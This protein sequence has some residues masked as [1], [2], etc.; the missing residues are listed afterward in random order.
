MSEKRYS[1]CVTYPNKNMLGQYLFFRI[2]DYDIDTRSLTPAT[3][4]SVSEEDLT[5]PRIIG[6]LPKD[7]AANMAVIREWGFKE[8]GSNRTISTRYPANV[9]EVIFPQELNTI[10][11]TDQSRIREVL[12]D[13]IMIDKNAGDELLIIIGSISSQY[14]ALHCSKKNMIHT[15]SIYKIHSSMS[16]M[17]HS[18]HYLDEYYIDKPDVLDTDNSLITDADGGKVPTRYFYRYT[19]LPKKICNFPLLDLQRYVPHYISKCLKQKKAMLQ[20]SDHDIQNISICIREIICDYD[21]VQ[22]YFQ[23]TGYDLTQLGEVLPRYA[24]EICKTLLNDTDADRIISQNLFKIVDVRQKCVDIAKGQ[25]LSEKNTEKEALLAEIEKFSREVATE[26][27]RRDTIIASA[28]QADKRR[29][30]LENEIQQIQNDQ[31]IAKG[32]LEQINADIENELRGFSDK[33]VHHVAISSLVRSIGGTEKSSSPIHSYTSIPKCIEG[34]NTEIIDKESLEEELAENLALCGYRVKAYEIAQ[35]IVHCALNSRP[36]IVSSNGLSIANCLSVLFC[37][38]GAAIVN[39][40]LGYT[41]LAG[42]TDRIRNV[43]GPVV[44][45]TGVFDGFSENV[46][47][48]IKDSCN[49]KILLIAADG[50]DAGMLSSAVWS[51]ALFLDIDLAFDYCENEIM[52]SA[53]VKGFPFERFYKENEI[54][55]KKKLL[56]PLLEAGILSN[57]AAVLCAKLMV[58][59]NSDIKSDWLVLL[60]LCVNAKARH[61]EDRLTDILEALGVNEKYTDLLAQYL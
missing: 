30:E 12:F 19:D 28:E 44:Y 20:L 36:L 27:L 47:H 4:F 46:F 52:K 8:D 26:S 16:D 11:I 35:L 48:A 25:W 59:I 13:G 33:I 58:D 49:N 53:T 39:I 22:N 17:L 60:Q 23:V 40:P 2:A 10:D 41:D 6:A 34:S 21:Q 1:L 7:A 43:Y 14:V 61:K 29:V 50:V 24:D 56:K 54:E 45:L 18:I 37:G 51:S 38:E 15:G 55:E 3:F 42:I 32:K 5:Y 31:M 57:T 9:Y